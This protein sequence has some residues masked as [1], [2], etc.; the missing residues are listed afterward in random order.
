M[1]RT[2]AIQG[3]SIPQL[4]GRFRFSPAFRLLLACSWIPPAAREPSHL[5]GMMAFIENGYRHINR[6]VEIEL[7]WRLAFWTPGQ[8]I[9]LWENSQVTEWL[10]V[11]FR[12]LSWEALILFLCGHGAYHCWSRIKW[13]SDVVVILAGG[14]KLDWDRVLNLA[15]RF[16]L[17]RSLAQGVLLVH[18]LYDVPL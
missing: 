16:N 5:A 7:H 18:W 1:A 10:G 4:P 9:E 3:Y 15:G 11:R 12:Q 2:M 17:R 6:S 14:H 13:L 8:V